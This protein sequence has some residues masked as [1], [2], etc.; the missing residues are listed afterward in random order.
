MALNWGVAANTSTYR[1]DYRPEGPG[2]WTVDDDTLTGASHAVGGLLCDRAY[3][4]RVSAYG[5]GTVYAAAWS[6]PSAV[7]TASTGALA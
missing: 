4:F 6:E 1:V 3:E 7:L 5:S 2:A